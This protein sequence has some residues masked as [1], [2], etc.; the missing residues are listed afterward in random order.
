MLGIFKRRKPDQDD[1]KRRECP[2]IDPVCCLR[3][4]A[5]ASVCPL[6]VIEVSDALALIEEGCNNCGLCVKACPLGGITP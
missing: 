5:C 4:G 1:S 3:C 6:N 2:K